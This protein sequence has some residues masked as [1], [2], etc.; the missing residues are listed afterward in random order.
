MLNWPPIVEL[1]IELGWLIVRLELEPNVLL[2]G[3]LIVDGERPQDT[4]RDVGIECLR[5]PVDRGVLQLETSGNKESAVDHR[6]AGRGDGPAGDLNTERVGR[7]QRLAVSVREP[8]IPIIFAT[9]A[10]TSKVMSPPML[11]TT[12]PEPGS[13]G[14]KYHRPRNPSCSRCP[15]SR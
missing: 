3:Q 8:P 4:A 1:E 10:L 9:F 7:C 5:A 11:V 12:K 6:G 14:S 13:S 2:A 15:S